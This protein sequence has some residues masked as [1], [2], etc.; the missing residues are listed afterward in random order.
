VE[1][2]E[3]TTLS[4][5]LKSAMKA[6]K[7]AHDFYKS[8]AEKF[9]DGSKIN[10]TLSYFADMETGHYKILETEVESIERFEEAD[11]YWEMVHVG[12]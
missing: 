12:P 8:F 9:P 5:I 10:Q 4:T 11:V 6:E 3:D 1:V 2:K 7:S